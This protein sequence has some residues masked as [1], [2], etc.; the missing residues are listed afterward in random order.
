MDPMSRRLFLTVLSFLALALACGAPDA[1]EPTEADPT[2]AAAEVDWCWEHGVPES[3][4]TI[5]NPELIP[6]YKAKGDWCAPHNLPESVCHLCGHGV[7]PPAG[8]PPEDVHAGTRIRFRSEEIEALAGIETAPAGHATVG[9]GV[10]ATASIGFHGDRFAEVRAPAGAVVRSLTVDLGER[11]ARGATLALMDSAEVGSLRATL[12]AS[13]ERERSAQA[14]LDRQRELREAGVASERQVE[15]ASR[16]LEAAS[17]AVRAALAALDAMGA[18][19]DGTGAR[20]A[21]RAPIAG[22]VIRRP[23]VLGSAVSPTD[24]LVVLA[25]PELMWANLALREADAATVSVGDGVEVEIDGIGDGVFQGTITWTSAEVDPITRT[26]AARAE[27]PNPEGRLR[28][29]QFGRAR[30]Q[31]QQTAEGVVVPRDALQRLDDGWVVFV[32]VEAGLYEPRAVDRGASIGDRV[33]VNGPIEAGEPVVTT[34]AFL[35]KTELRRDAI[36]AGC[37]EIE[38]EEG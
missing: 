23:A 36:G 5:C 15:Q 6:E 37:C 3:A 11:V 33:E 2:S 22:E 32:R 30:I 18:S 9:G 25:D 17:G 31:A 35:L 16:E 19:P 38:H 20:F 13:R 34:G 8:G 24:L 27:L 1:P 7:E 4:C 26:V 14:D 10:P 21:L 29:N 12:D 28:G